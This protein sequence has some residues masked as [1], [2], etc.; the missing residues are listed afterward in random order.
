VTAPEKGLADKLQ[1]VS[2]SL[3][4]VILN[5]NTQAILKLFII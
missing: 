5:Y 3:K 4:E 1:N 2:S